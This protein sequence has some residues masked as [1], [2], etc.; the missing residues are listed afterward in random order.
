MAKGR[1]GRKGSGT[2]TTPTRVGG[3]ATP[4]TEDDAGKK[5]KRIPHPLVDNADEKKY[6]F[7]G[8]PDDFDASKHSS[9][10]KKDFKLDHMY[11]TYRADHL[12]ATVKDMRSKAELA[13]K[14]GSSKDRAKAKRLVKMQSKMKEL[15]EQL[16]AQG[17]DVDGILAAQD[18]D[19]KE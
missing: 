15:R 11:F 17:V 18:A 3:S 14:L 1:K 4:G 8:V 16:V 12:E 6:P 13:K 2:D 19:E 10:K 9:L 7:D 5:K